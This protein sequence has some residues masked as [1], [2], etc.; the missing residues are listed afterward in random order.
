MTH[1][2]RTPFLVL[3][4]LDW[5][6][7][8]AQKLH[9][10]SSMCQSHEVC[11]GTAYPRIATDTIDY[12]LTNHDFPGFCLVSLG[13]DRQ[14]C[15]TRFDYYF[16]SGLS[17]RLSSCGHFDTAVKAMAIQTWDGNF[18]RTAQEGDLMLR[19]PQRP[20][21]RRLR[22]MGLGVSFVSTDF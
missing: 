5:R 10:R 7:H 3:L 1:S 20:L 6:T 12:H 22:H 19:R 4:N 16:R 11:A 13:Q 17:F 18:A 15:G 9:R 21:L 8:C 14:A 2:K